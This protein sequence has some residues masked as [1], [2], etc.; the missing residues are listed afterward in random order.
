MWLERRLLLGMP[1]A[2]MA[3]RGERC[4]IIGA[5]SRGDGDL[6]V[7]ETPAERRLAG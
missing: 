6:V 4:R 7:A 5:P 1:N 3:V 2:L